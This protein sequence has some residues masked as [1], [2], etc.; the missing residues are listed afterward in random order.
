MITDADSDENIS[1]IVHGDED[2]VVGKD[3]DLFFVR[4][5]C[6]IFLFWSALDRWGSDCSEHHSNV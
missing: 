5:D 6:K 3:P 4:R 2:V 1:V